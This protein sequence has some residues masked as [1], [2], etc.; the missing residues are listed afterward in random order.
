MGFIR[1]LIS[2]LISFENPPF[3]MVCGFYDFNTKNFTNNTSISECLW[4]RTV[5]F[6][7][8]NFSEQFFCPDEFEFITDEM[9]CLESNFTKGLC[10]LNID[11]VQFMK[12]Q[13]NWTCEV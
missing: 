10:Q 1:Y 7:F 2:V 6:E 8:G 5:E 3:S 12:H 13:G 11:E 9:N 4:T